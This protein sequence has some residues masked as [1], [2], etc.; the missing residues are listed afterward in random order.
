MSP[1]VVGTQAQSG[2]AR[3]GGQQLERSAT[4]KGRTPSPVDNAEQ[5]GCDVTVAAS[6]GALII[7]V[8]I[9]GTG[10]DPC[11]HAE[12]AATELAVHTP[13][14]TKSTGAQAI[15]VFENERYSAS[16]CPGSRL[17]ASASSARRNPLLFFSSANITMMP[18][19]PRT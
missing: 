9:G 17:M 11:P 14:W 8:T 1:A 5:R 10:E 13:V 12:A 4:Y 7:E 6:R 18:L 15:T 2:P 3:G 16:D 19:G